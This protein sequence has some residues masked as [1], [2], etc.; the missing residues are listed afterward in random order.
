M[1]VIEAKWEKRNLGVLAYEISVEE[2]DTLIDIKTTLDRLVAEYTVVKIPTYRTELLFETNSLGLTFVEMVTKCHYT[3]R[4]PALNGIHGRLI[5]SLSC[6]EIS[7]ANQMNLFV[8]VGNGLFKADRVAIDPDF[9]IAKSSARYVGW[10]KDEVDLGARIFEVTKGFE[11]V[12]FFLMRR[13]DLGRSISNLAGLI[14]KFQNSGMGYA[15]NY[16][17]IEKSSSMGANSVISTF[18]SNNRGASAIHMSMGYVLDSQNY[19]YIR[20]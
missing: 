4:A 13:I 7:P 5:E 10:I 18:S 1:K 6:Q 15:L 12:G 3:G 8:E 2:E 11:F 19:V 16:F 14:G 9:G 17:E 20:H